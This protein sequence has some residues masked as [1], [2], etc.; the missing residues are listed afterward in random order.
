ME[1]ELEHISYGEMLRAGTVRPG[2]GSAVI[3]S[4]YIIH[5]LFHCTGDGAV[6]QAAQRF[7]G[8][9]LGDIQKPSRRG[10]RQPALGVPAAAGVGPGGPR[11]PANTAVL[12]FWESFL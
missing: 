5:I 3:S 4:V 10:P 12:C 6:T 7:W 11:G 2:E 1:K 8:L 9:L